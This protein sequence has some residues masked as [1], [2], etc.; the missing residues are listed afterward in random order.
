VQDLRGKKT[1]KQNYSISGKIDFKTRYGGKIVGG[2]N[3]GKNN[4][5]GNSPQQDRTYG[6]RED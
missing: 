1:K 6:S 4:V 2:G 3:K 5:F